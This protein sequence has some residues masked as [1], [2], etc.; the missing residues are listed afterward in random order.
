MISEY[1]NS[2]DP[3][4]HVL[5]V[6]ADVIV[7]TLPGNHDNIQVMIDTLAASGKSVMFGDES[8]GDHNAALR[9]NG[10]VM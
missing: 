8:W 4:D 10:G 3:P 9:I 5:M 1:L 6:D 2:E 7:H